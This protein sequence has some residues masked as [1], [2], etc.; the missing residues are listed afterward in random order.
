MGDSG[1]RVQG[2]RLLLRALRPDEIDGEWERMR[3][4]GPLAVAGVPDEARFRARLARS[5][6]MTDGWLDLAIDLD[7]TA[8]GRIQTFV[9]PDRELPPGTYDI[10][11][12][13]STEARGHGYGTEALALLAGWLFEHAGAEVLEGATAPANAAMRAVLRHCGWTEAGPVTEV[14]REWVMYT[15]TRQQWQVT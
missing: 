4:A 6:Q 5:G 2:P 15:L 9:P 12:G 11:I 14:G 8:I 1:I 3:A 7:G 13:L 10:G